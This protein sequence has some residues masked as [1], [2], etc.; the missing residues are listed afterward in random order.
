MAIIVTDYAFL[1]MQKSLHRYE[2]ELNEAIDMF[3]KNT[4]DINEVIEALKICANTNGGMKR[5]RELANL[6][7]DSK[8]LENI[9]NVINSTSIKEDERTRYI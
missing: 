6:N 3:E 7:F 2:A 1:E 4:E 8:I 9:K 5:A